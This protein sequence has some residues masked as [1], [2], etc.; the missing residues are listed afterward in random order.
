MATAIKLKSSRR[1]NGIL[2]DTNV[3]P[4]FF[5]P[6]QRAVLQGHGVALPSDKK[7]DA[8]KHKFRGRFFTSAATVVEFLCDYDPAPAVALP[9]LA[10]TTKMAPAK[11]PI[12]GRQNL[13]QAVAAHSEAFSRVW[14]HRTTTARIALATI[15]SQAAKVW[16]ASAQ[17]AATELALLKKLVDPYAVRDRGWVDVYTAQTAI[18]H[19]LI[20]LTTD[21]SDFARIAGVKYLVKY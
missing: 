20:V 9:L 5:T 14:K 21:V 2:L 15:Q 19:G 17:Q 1:A 12:P 11:T 6:G 3:I 16:P 8:V 18:D 4:Y 13:L 10:S 7:F